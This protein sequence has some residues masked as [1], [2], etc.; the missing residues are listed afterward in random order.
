MVP[1]IRP[2][3]QL[4]L[5]SR[6]AQRIETP[7]AAR[8]RRRGATVH[9][10][11]RRLQG[12]AR[13]TRRARQDAGL[14][15]GRHVHAETR[16]L[17]C[18][19]LPRHR[20]ARGTAPLRA[21]RRGRPADRQEGHRPPRPGRGPRGG[22]GAEARQPPRGLRSGGPRD[23]A[24]ASAQPRERDRLP[25]D[26]PHHG[27]PRDLPPPRALERRARAGRDRSATLP[28]PAPARSG[29]ARRAARAAE[30]RRG[31]PRRGRGRRRS[32]S[33]QD[34]RPDRGAEAGNHRLRPRAPDAEG[35]P[36][37]K[38]RRRARGADRLHQRGKIHAHARPHRQ[39]SAGGQQALRN[40]RHH[41]ARPR[42]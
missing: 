14:P 15:G 12:L 5:L 24:F 39:R 20:Q 9:G 36:A 8:R 35:P 37:G 1:Q 16:E 41:R 32:G 25:G 27:D 23:L 10:Q 4:A 7:P 11:R 42:P 17:P 29:Q 33:R 22:Q 3:R 21:G 13:R 2:S 28:R 19:R 6:H 38:F 26:G 30:E 18:R 40:A 34:P 31:R